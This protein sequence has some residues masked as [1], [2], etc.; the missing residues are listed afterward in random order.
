VDPFF[1]IVIPTYNR[2]D[3]IMQTLNSVLDQQFKDFEI[4]LVDDGSTDHTGSLIRQVKDSRLLYFKKENGE[5]GAARNFGILRASG[6]YITFLDSDDR[7][8]PDFFM[9]AKKFI[10]EKKEPAFFHAGYEIKD[11]NGQVINRVVGSNGDLNKKLAKGNFLSCIGVFVRQDV[12]KQHL[13]NE[14]RNLA[15]SEDYELWMRIASRYPLLS[16]GKVS[17]YM[18]QHEGRSVLNFDEEELE[19]RVN[20]AFEYLK[21]DKAV[22]AFYKGKMATVRAHLDMYIALHLAMK[23]KKSKAIYYIISALGKDAKVMF[24]RKMLSLGYKML[25]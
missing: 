14:D 16:T 23:R 21:Q 22:S 6:A 18:V 9:S 1:S 17:A 15:G 4:I 3:H 20:L 7:L 8:Y 5:R 10:E 11:E 2:A 25:R 12:I 24:T 13:F 19:R